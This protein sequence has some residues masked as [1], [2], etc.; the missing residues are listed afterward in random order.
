MKDTRFAR[1]STKD[2]VYEEIFVWV[3]K[4]ILERSIEFNQVVAYV[5]DNLIRNKTERQH[6]EKK[7]YH[8]SENQDLITC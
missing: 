7:S 5:E 3:F 4:L 6:A 1:L 2:I 8:D